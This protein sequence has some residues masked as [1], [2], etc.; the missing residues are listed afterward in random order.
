M[1]EIPERRAP[2]RLAD[3]LNPTGARK[4]HSLIDKVYK[5]KNLEMAWEK[6]EANQGAGGVDGESIEAFGARSQERLNQ[7]HEELKADRY[8]PLP[9]RQKPI[10]KPDQ[11]NEY[12]MLGIPAIVDRVCQQALVNR[13]EPIFEPT[14][15]AASFGYRRGL[16][17]KDALRK[18]WKEI[19]AGA[20]WIVDADLRDFFGSADQTKLLTLI[21]QQVSDGRVLRLIESMLKAGAWGEGRLFPTERGV[22]QGGV[23][24]PLASNILLT[25]FDRE[26]RRK[27]YQLTRYAD[28]WCITCTSAAQARAALKTAGRILEQLSVQLHP[29]KTRIVH[30]R[31]GFR[32]LG[33]VIKRGSAPMRRPQSMIK[34]TQAGALYAFPQDKS[35]HR[36][37]EKVRRLTRRNAPVATEAL[38]PEINP[39]LRGWGEHYKRAHVRRLFRQLDSWIVRRLWAH[40]GRRWRSSAWRQLPHKKL[41]GELKLVR[42]RDL[43]PSRS[44][45]T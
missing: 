42:L 19:E 33:F 3:W 31:G 30:V 23:I 18:V 2:R 28:D 36:F 17:T 26:M 41:Y 10:P 13:L 45:P 39:L 24:S 22:P 32:F 43:L 44:I 8:Q 6:V 11:P 35:V 9:V 15:D 20:E 7:L 38:I 5:R 25:P 37:K 21:S 14:F 27:G 12:R 1:S 40:R 34:S 4:V 29:R 16:S